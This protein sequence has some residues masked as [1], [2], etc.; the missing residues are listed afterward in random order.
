MKYFTSDLHFFD[1]DIIVFA[2]RPYE[3]PEAMN[4]D[5]IE[6]F[7][8]RTHDAS[9][10]YILGD[11]FGGRLPKDQFGSLKSVMDRLGINDRPFHL[12]RGNHDHL[13]DDEYLKIGFQ[14][15]Y[16][17]FVYTGLT[18]GLQVMISHDP[19][20]VQPRNTLA[21]CGHIHTLFSENWQPLR[22]TFTV[23]VGVEM[24]DYAPISEAE[25]LDIIA[26]SPYKLKARR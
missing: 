25:I 5:L 17:N 6:R 4:E 10:I 21:L 13:A 20:M 2:D 18:G 19:C 12:M 16:S 3:N 22:N 1:S 11:I 14:T 9:E 15:I 24:R 23:N 26:K 8:A 7:N